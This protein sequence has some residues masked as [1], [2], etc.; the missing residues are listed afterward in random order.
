[1]S[2][3]LSGDA[4]PAGAA[5]M[6]LADLVAEV[7][8]IRFNA[9]Q[10]SQIQRWLNDRLAALW[11]AE[12]WVFKYAKT[13]VTVTAGSSTVGG[14]PTDMGVPVGFYRADGT[15]ILHRPPRDFYNQY[16][17]GT[18]TGAP[19]HYT[20]LNQALTVGPVSNETSSSYTLVYQRRMSLLTTDTD[21][22][23]IPTEHH[24]LLVTGALSMGCRLY[25]DFTWTF[26]EQ[27]WQQGI[28]EMRAEW[29]V[30]QRGEAGV[31]GRDPVEALPT[32]WGN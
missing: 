31:W 19:V 25:N 23:A 12:E 9:Q 32:S 26:Q 16:A 29:L 1:M 7:K 28:Q 24:Y 8:T 17:G 14:L 5:P 27:A 3:I 15:P 2:I 10:G 6:T 30:D 21:V 20:A 22:P 11:N 4:T 13:T 18:D